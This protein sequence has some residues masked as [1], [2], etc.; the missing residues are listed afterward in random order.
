MNERKNNTKILSLFFIILVLCCSFAYAITDVTAVGNIE[1]GYALVMNADIADASGTLDSIENVPGYVVKGI[2]IYVGYLVGDY[3]D[4]VKIGDTNPL[5]G[6]DEE[7][8]IILSSSD[9]EPDKNVTI[10][11]AADS[12][13][14]SNVSVDLDFNTGSG[15]VREDDSSF[16][17][18]IGAKSYSVELGKDE[19]NV[20][21]TVIGDNSRIS[22]TA[23]PG[24]PKGMKTPIVAYSVL[25]WDPATYIP[26]GN[27][28]AD[29]SVVIVNEG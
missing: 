17:L 29:V 13:V 24:P 11:I 22:L 26:A 7:A 9:V 1:G 2:R 15:W 19:T 6:T 23:K 12:N 18:G 20:T 28:N 8:S 14:K 16:S 4:A 25:S 3:S 27:Y 10:Y 5:T 21:A